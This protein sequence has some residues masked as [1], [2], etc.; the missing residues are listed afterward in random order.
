MGGRRWTEVGNG[1]RCR[2][3]PNKPARGIM[4]CLMNASGFL[5]PVLP[6]RKT[7]LEG[8]RFP[9]KLAG[10]AGASRRG[11]ETSLFPWLLLLPL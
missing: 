2:H 7:G 9:I 10:R 11:K 5:L 1:Q 6:E 3:N 8:D 4:R